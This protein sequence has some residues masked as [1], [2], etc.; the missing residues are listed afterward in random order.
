MPIQVE[1]IWVE[2]HARLLNFIRRRVEDE[3]AAEDILQDVFVKVQSRIGTLGKERKLAAWLYQIT[4]NAIIDYY[5][6]YRPAEAMPKALAAEEQEL[7]EKARREI[8]GCL[9][10]MIQ[11]LPDKYRQAIILSEIEE[12]PQKQVAKRLGLSWSGA[13]SRIQRGRLM[14]KNTLLECCR[15]E[16]DT[17]GNVVNCESQDDSCGPC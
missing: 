14:L 16:Y 13:K 4:R 7:T 17:L 1:T 12:L 10:P 5:R 3:A 6:A 15:F 11:D 8:E 9:E 2:Y